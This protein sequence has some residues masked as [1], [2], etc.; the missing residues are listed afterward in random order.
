MFQTCEDT[1]MVL[2]LTIYSTQNPI[3]ITEAIIQEY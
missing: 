1:G 3:K 2:V